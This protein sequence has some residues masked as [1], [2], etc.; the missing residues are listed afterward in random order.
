MAN[1]LA[2][3]AREYC[4]TVG[5][6]SLVLTG[7]VDTPTLGKFNT[8]AN[9]G[10]TDG[11]VVTYAIE[12]TTGR[13]VGQGTYTSATK[14]LSRDT[15]YS[16]TNGG[17]KLSLSGGAQVFVTPAASDLFPGPTTYG[18][19]GPLSDKHS[20]STIFRLADRLFV[21]AGVQ[22]DGTSSGS[23]GKTFL[24]DASNLNSYWAERNAAFLGVSN[25][26][27]GGGVFGS[28]GSDQYTYLGATVWAQGQ[29]VSIG[30]KRGYQQKIYTA[31]SSGTTGSTPPTHTTGTQSDG[32][33]NWTFTEN[34]YMTPIGMTAIVMNDVLDGNAVWA[35]YVEAQRA[36]GAGTCYGFEIDTKNKGSNVV[37]DS[38]NHLPIGSTH[39]LWMA[40]GGDA[41]LGAPANPSSAALVVGEN[42]TTWN[43]G[44]VFAKDGITGA[45]GTGGA[46]TGI[47][48][49]YAR[50]HQNVWY[51]S[52]G[53]VGFRIWG[54]VATASKYVDVVAT[55]DLLAV[56]VRGT[57]QFGV[58]NGSVAVA[59]TLEL[60]HATDTTLSR[61]G[62]G[63]IAVEGNAIY[64]A[65]GTDVP[66]LDGGTGASTAATARS[67]LGA[68]ASGANSDITSLGTLTSGLT[69]ST[70]S[71][72]SNFL[73]I[74]TDAGAGSGPF[75]SARRT[76]ASPAAADGIGVFNFQ[77]NNSTPS[78]VNYCQLAAYLL[79]P[80]AASEDAY[81]DFNTMVAG[82]LAA[83]LS[84]RQGIIVGSPTGGD[85]GVG[86]VNATAVYDD[87]VLLT[88]PG[89]EFFQSGAVNTATWDALVPDQ[90]IP[91]S[92]VAI[93]E[94]DVLIDEDVEVDEVDDE[95]GET[96]KVTTTRQRKESR[97]VF[98][99][100]P[101]QTIRRTHKVAHEF[102]AL[103]ATGFDPRDPKQYLKKFKDEGALPGLPNR[104]NWVHG[105][106]S[107]GEMTNKQT[108]AMEMMAMTI[109]TM[110]D[111]IQ[112]L[113]KGGKP[114]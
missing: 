13:E 30:D 18:A 75:I 101:A 73:A 29:N 47:A 97:V 42:A 107:V 102:A 111:E 108:L 92:N 74:S 1:V 5:T 68:A 21:G 49:S 113:K 94:E 35:G 104:T 67:N 71:L 70:A 33:V 82:T 9:A 112:A 48:I 6:G 105:S 16:S 85:K 54:D 34:T 88:C 22:N 55:D 14:T 79:D 72:I 28:R 15:V 25:Y 2:N 17:S 57:Q 50:G 19:I 93:G 53:N 103:L 96:K 76:S 99:A 12:D 56:K 36:S 26:G 52:A 66:V 83:R 32:A 98:K 62:A 61:T 81:F 45:D 69:V 65:G 51:A 44:I 109:A 11:Q 86:T 60:G 23:G 39:G 114:S 80:T 100:A 3:L 31:A 95:T 24:G 43:K 110:Y 4:S 20:G 78:N 40:A 91:A 46:N 41:T 59:G 89:G 58:G 106:H 10:I 87:S 8:F 63:D 64:R 37:P 90:V 38:Y 27:G 7:A 84:V 77:G